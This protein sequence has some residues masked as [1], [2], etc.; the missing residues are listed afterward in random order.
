MTTLDDVMAVANFNRHVS[1]VL[2][3]LITVHILADFAVFKMC[4]NLVRES[5]KD[6]AAARRFFDMAVE[7]G[8]VTD[9]RTARV[10]EAIKASAES[11]VLPPSIVPP[12]ARN[13]GCGPSTL[14]PVVLALLVVG[15]E[16]NRMEAAQEMRQANAASALAWMDEQA[17][18]PL[19]V[20]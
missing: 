4:L 14:V 3:F 11:G 5:R 8:K 7:Q 6:V 1:Y 20:S 18:S 16:C 17:D 10:E 2:L 15:W 19:S 12:E 13:G 9:N